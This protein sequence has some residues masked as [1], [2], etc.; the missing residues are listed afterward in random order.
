[1]ARLDD[2]EKEIEE[3]KKNQETLIEHVNVLIDRLN[4]ERTGVSMFEIKTWEHPYL[5]YFVYKA[6]L[7]ELKDSPDRYVGRRAV[8][9]RAVGAYDVPRSK[10]KVRI[11][12]LVDEGI[13]KD[14]DGRVRPSPDAE[15]LE[16]DDLFLSNVTR[17]EELD[18]YR[19][20]EDMDS[21]DR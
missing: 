1:M 21:I 20:V 5:S 17:R 18:S 14:R 16:P 3:L 7:A 6:V 15:K 11:R 4:V 13:L 10:V 19:D 2:L 9:D 8:K 12:N